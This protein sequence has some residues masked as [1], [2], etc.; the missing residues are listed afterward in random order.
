MFGFA[1]CDA[2]MQALSILETQN[3]PSQR[4][5][6]MAADCSLNIE[7]IAPA[8][9]TFLSH[10]VVRAQRAHDAARFGQPTTLFFSARYPPDIE[11]TKHDQ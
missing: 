11:G 6:N 3:S 9:R 2:V 5:R 10:L 1:A 7:L 8:Q 4:Q